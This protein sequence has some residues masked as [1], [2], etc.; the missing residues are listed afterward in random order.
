MLKPDDREECGGGVTLGGVDGSPRDHRGADRNEG[1]GSHR[2]ERAEQEGNL[3]AAPSTAISH[4][5]Q[6]M[7]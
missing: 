2:S 7:P 1:G 6:E 3:A 4:R 5:L